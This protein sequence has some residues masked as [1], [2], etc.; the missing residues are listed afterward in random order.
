MTNI[1][2]EKSTTYLK[3][4]YYKFQSAIADYKADSIM[5]SHPIFD[6]SFDKAKAIQELLDNIGLV[7]WIVDIESIEKENKSLTTKK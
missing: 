4:I 6:K 5:A 2:H 7:D 3:A 1:N